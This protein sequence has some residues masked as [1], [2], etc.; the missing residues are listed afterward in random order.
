MSCYLGIDIGS[1]TVKLVLFDE[2]KQVLYKSYQR[3]FS[4]TLQT[5]QKELNIILEKY[6]DKEIKVAITG[7]GGMELANTTNVPF[8][9]E[10]FATSLYVDKYYPQVDVVIELGGEDAKI[11]FF[12]V[13]TEEKM[14]GTCAGG[15]G[16]FIDQ[17]A[18]LLNVTPA[19]M[20]AL[21]LNANAVYPIASRCGVFAKSDIQP[22]LNQG[23]SKENIAA[24]VYNAVAEQTI[25]GLAGGH[26]IEGNV[27]F[28]GGPLTFCQGL[29]NAFLSQLPEIK[30]IFIE[31]A[32]YFVAFGTAFY[33]SKTDTTVLISELLDR[34]EKAKGNMK[35]LASVCL[36]L[37]K[38]EQEYDLFIQRHNRADVNYDKNLQN[39]KC[40]YIGID[41]G[42]TTTKTVAINQDSEIIFTA[43]APNK[44]NPV[45]TVRNQLIDF[46]N[47]CPNVE[48]MYSV[49]T[50]YG[51]ELI[52]NAFNVDYGVV[53]TMAHYTG[54]KFFEPDVDFIIDIG[55]QDMKCF[56]I[57]NGNVDS[58]TLNEACSSGC[59]SF[60]Q[61]FAKSMGHTVEE[62]EKIALFAESPVDLGSRC[63]VFMNSSV[64]QA[65]KNGASIQDISAGLAIS[66][67]KN[68][69]FKVLRVN[70]AKQIGE[71]I[72]VQGGTFTNDAVL[73]AFEQL[74][75]ANVIRPSIAGLM[76][77]FG[78]ALMGL[79]RHGEKSSIYSKE[80]LENFTH[81]STH[82]RCN[83]CQNHC[84]LTINKFSNNGRYISGNRC[85]RPTGKQKQE[86][87]PNV[88]NIKQDYLSKYFIR[89]NSNVTIGI[90]LVLNFYDNLPFWV[91]LFDN[92]G[93]SVKVSGFSNREIYRKGQHTIP[94]DTVCYG[95]KLVHGHI[96]KLIEDDK[97]D[98]I[99]YPCMSYNKDEGKS[100]NNYHCPV[101]AYYPELIGANVKDV[102]K[103]TYLNGFVDINNFKNLANQ[104]LQML[105]KLD[106]KL[107]KKDIL[108]ALKSAQEE[109]N[110]YRTNIINAGKKAIKY[111]KDNNVKSVVLSG[112]PYHVDPELNHG[113]DKMI[114]SLGFV[115]LSEDCLDCHDED[116]K[117]IGV[118]NQWTYH[119]RMYQAAKK[120]INMENTELV[121]LISFGCG[122]DAVTSDEVKDILVNGGKLYTGLKIDEINN[123]GTVKIRMRSLLAAMEERGKQNE[124]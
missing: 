116:V 61:S 71:K 123:L 26:P 9:Q 52:K 118:L 41:A 18:T 115:I 95:A 91:T 104:L 4:K 74:L 15:T 103:I 27:M 11:V 81:T 121:Q 89:K 97:V 111:A 117:N 110:N 14:N 44:G 105:S 122:L 98:A 77:A 80:E 83:Y 96:I 109:Q 120:V 87:L 107:T 119:S 36:P 30:P 1:T 63:T 70:D 24:S 102:E 32:E 58:I 65:Q 64:K 84:A 48:V 43:Y 112:R 79:Q 46:Y 93:F 75:G 56:G 45:E 78:C 49:V 5:V 92:L 94:S 59:G 62:F 114:S 12:G 68:A 88:Y 86:D 25:G 42:S 33:A 100:N 60:L 76:G 67:V 108:K 16:A 50:G 85:S 29:R 124:K 51:E 17:M 47:S 6:G 7:S 69:L 22:L 38:N 19:E 13:N 21:S 8:V 54:A 39:T 57:K 23:A 101:V 82:V 40:A 73:R 2:Q 37:F 90:P 106:S 72:V 34:I 31:D 66:V 113:I 35:K 53:E 20:D 3:H 99:F 55:G 10:V 28:L